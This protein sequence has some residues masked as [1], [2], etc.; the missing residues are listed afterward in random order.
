MKLYSEYPFASISM[1]KDN[2]FKQ[3]ITQ[4]LQ[5]GQVKS[6]VES[7]TY[8]GLGSTTMLCELIAENNITLNHFYTIE[9]EEPI[10]N[11]AVLN[12]KKYPFV[13]PLWGMSLS[14]EECLNFIEHDE[15]I[16]NHEKYPDIF[17][18]SIENPKEFYKNEIEG[19]LS[20][21]IPDKKSI[22][23]TIRSFFQKPSIRKPV[24]QNCFK[25]Y[26]PLIENDCPI[27][28]LDSAGGVGLLEFQTVM[29]LMKDKTFYLILD[30]VHH[31]KHFR[32]LDFVRKN[33]S[34]NILAESLEQGWVIA[35]Y[36]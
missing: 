17:I 21:K 36:L 12:L 15:A 5:E 20:I 1:S 29:S 25:R 23:V 6:I 16:N 7:G 22:I 26:I 13:K 19:S 9:V 32:S 24:P 31:L 28:L 8:N 33:N 30:D 3:V 18:D 4:L 35:K 27:I 2:K 11:Q 14:K 34:F 10:Y